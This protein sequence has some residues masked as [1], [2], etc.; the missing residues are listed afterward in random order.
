MSVPGSV[1]WRNTSILSM[2]MQCR[3]T[4]ACS[5]TGHGTSRL[6]EPAA[7]Q[8][9][10]GRRACR[11]TAA[12]PSTCGECV[13]PVRFS[14]SSSKESH[15]ACCMLLSNICIRAAMRPCAPRY[16]PLL[17]HPAPGESAL[18]SEVLVIIEQGEPYCMLH[19]VVERLRQGSNTTMSFRV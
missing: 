11:D 2:H 3:R 13:W 4:V 6:S 12:A 19:V 18:A 8:S 9:R 7:A 17:L 16:R 15:L 10:P 1:V 5:C 14:S